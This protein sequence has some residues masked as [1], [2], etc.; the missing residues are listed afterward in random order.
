MSY[1]K[2]RI[3]WNVPKQRDIIVDMIYFYL[4]LLQKY[5]NRAKLSGV[6]SMLF[7]DTYA[8]VTFASGSKLLVNYI[9][10]DAILEKELNN[11]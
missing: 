1:L 6:R 3:E 11:E 2:S 10:L 4:P 8:I 5:L 7:E 9:T